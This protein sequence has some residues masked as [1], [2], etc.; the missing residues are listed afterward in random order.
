[1]QECEPMKTLRQ[2]LDSEFS[3]V[4]PAPGGAL[5]GGGIRTDHPADLYLAALA[6]KA[7]KR[8]VKTATTQEY[9]ERHLTIVKT[10]RL[11]DEAID[12]KIIER[13]GAWLLEFAH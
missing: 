8:V 7:K 4:L 9:L 3:Y 13:V 10:S 11:F 2:F 5:I 1:M 6:S 12:A